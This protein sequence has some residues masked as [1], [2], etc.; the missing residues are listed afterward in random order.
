MSDTHTSVKADISVARLQFDLLSGINAGRLKRTSRAPTKT[1]PKAQRA[2]PVFHHVIKTDP[3]LTQL[4]RG[5]FENPFVQVVRLLFA[6]ASSIE[7][8]GGG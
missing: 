1:K 5:Y 4:R 3:I 8:L 2:G 6:P 7:W